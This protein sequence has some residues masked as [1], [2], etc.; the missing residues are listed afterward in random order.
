MIYIIILAVGVLATLLLGSRALSGPSPRKAL[1]RRMELVKE[2]HADGVLAANAQA[3]IRKLMAER[4]SRVEGIFSTLIPR[5]ALIEGEHTLKV[6][7]KPRRSFAS[8]SE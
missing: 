4:A 2:R 3:Q 6:S 8:P 1:K 5:P 7:V